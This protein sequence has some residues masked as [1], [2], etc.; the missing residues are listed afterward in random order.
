[1]QEAA[2]G[3]RVCHAAWLLLLDCMDS[4][5]IPVYIHHISGVA[6]VFQ[7]QGLHAQSL[8]ALHGGVIE[9]RSGC[10][11]EHGVPR[12]AG[13]GI[14]DV[15]LGSSCRRRSLRVF[16]KISIIPMS[17]IIIINVCTYSMYASIEGSLV[18]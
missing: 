7:G 6:A 1:M 13:A 15:Q 8:A 17:I 12:G 14:G 4:N 16:C 18:L 3:E 10:I 11:I 5:V 9:H 2:A